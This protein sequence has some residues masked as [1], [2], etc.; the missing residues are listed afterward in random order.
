MFQLPGF[1]ISGTLVENG[2]KNQICSK[3]TNERLEDHHDVINV[4]GRPSTLLKKESDTCVF[5][6]IL[7][8]S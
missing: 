5:L 3:S 2:L 4:A 8:N 6:Q 7:Q 1:Y